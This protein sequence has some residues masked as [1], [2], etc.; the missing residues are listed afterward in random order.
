MRGRPPGFFGHQISNLHLLEE[1]RGKRGEGEKYR[2]YCAQHYSSLSNSNSPLPRQLLSHQIRGDGE[3]IPPDYTQIDRI[4]DIDSENDNHVVETQTDD[5]DS[6]LPSSCGVPEEIVLDRSSPDYDKTES[7][8]RLILVKWGGI[9]YM[10]SIAAYERERDLIN[11]GIEYLPQA[12]LFYKRNRKPSKKWFEQKA[13]KS[14]HAQIDDYLTLKKG[15][16][17]SSRKLG[18]KAKYVKAKGKDKVAEVNEK[19]RVFK[20][21]RHELRRAHIRS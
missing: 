11:A 12:E 1:I 18:E 21:R 6:A 9:P 2:L 15:H 13:T 17:N 16:T 3:Y 10:E 20:E 14:V 19:V 7:K 5:P 4:L 8:G